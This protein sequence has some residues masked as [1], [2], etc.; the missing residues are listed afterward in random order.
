[1]NQNLELTNVPQRGMLSYE[2]YFR[3]HGYQLI[4]GVD[5][6]GR[7]PIAGPVVAAAVILES[8]ESV[9][10]SLEGLT[11]SKKLT[12]N[13]REKFYAEIQQSA[14]SVGVGMQTSHEIDETNILKATLKAMSQAIYSLVPNP[15]YVVVDGNR[16]PPVHIPCSTI[17]K[18]DR[19]SLSIAAAS[20]V[21]KVTRDQLMR[22][23]H[24]IYPEYGFDR[25]KGYP[26]SQHKNAVARFGPC[27]IHR[28]SFKLI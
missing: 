23:Y 16:K 14:V 12:E 22:E 24:K 13:Q 28:R 10:A 25:H 18:G 5:E 27:K 4:A 26:T 9:S 11:D 15:D 1:M 7:G 2:L 8:M 17:V 6:A 3:Q 19:L 20:V 21:A